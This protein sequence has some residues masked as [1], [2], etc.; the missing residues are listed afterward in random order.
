MKKYFLLLLLT[1]FGSITFGQIPPGYYD[2]AFNLS[3]TALQQALHNIIKD[4][5]S[6]TYNELWGDFASTDKKSNGKVW[7]MYSDVPGGTPPYEYT[8]FSNQCGNYN[9]EGDCYNREHSFPKSW[10]GGTV[11]PMYSDLFHL[12]P[13]DGYVNSKRSNYPYGE[14]NNASWTSMNG[15]KVGDNVYPGYS[16]TVFEPID[17]YKGDFARTYFYMATRYLGE[18][19][20]W[21]GSPMV[22]GSQPKEWA[23]N[24]LYEWHNNDPVSNKET[25]RNDAVYDIQHNRNPFI[26]HPEFVGMIWFNTSTADALLDRTD[27]NIFPNPVT[28]KIN[29][30]MTGRVAEGTTSVT[31]SGETGCT[32]Y[33]AS[34]PGESVI[35]IDASSL[36]KGFYL[37]TITKNNSRYPVTF[38]FVK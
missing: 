14:V 30:K 33:S 28:D 32:I 34:F 22:N 26:D 27:F 11:Y 21:P 36:S 35:S 9:S 2:P 12:Y 25:Q 24:M 18:D 31:I 20:N 15:C 4:H 16:G 7:D 37:L 5:D 6:E 13:T 19:G 10:F 17:D 1:Y 8:F 23:L 3:G 29:I 38:K